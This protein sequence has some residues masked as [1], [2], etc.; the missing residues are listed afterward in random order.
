[1]GAGEIA[2][3]SRRRAVEEIHAKR[4][5]AARKLAQDCQVHIEQ[6]V[7]RLPAG[8]RAGQAPGLAQ[9]PHRLIEKRSAALSALSMPCPAPALS[10]AS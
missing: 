10:A 3:P 8:P 6:A 9:L 2:E 7:E 1:M 4:G 5:V